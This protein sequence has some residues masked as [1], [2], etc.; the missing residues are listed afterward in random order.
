MKK[1]I[2][3]IGICWLGLTLT[4]LGAGFN[5]T[6][7]EEAPDAG[8]PDGFGVYG[9]ETSDRGVTENVS[10]SG[11]QAASITADFGMD[12]WGVI[13]LHEKGNWD[14]ANK[15]LSAQISSTVDFTGKKGVAAFKLIDADGSEYRT[16]DGDLFTPSGDWKEFR[17]SVS[18][19][20]QVEEPGKKPGLDLGHIVQ[21]GIIFFDHGEYDQVVTF[22]VDDFQTISQ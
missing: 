13:L 11:K 12:K 3:W 6:F 18:S 14:L 17:Q 10:T 9:D 8:A 2:Q 1:R 4:A 21:Y 19:V 7:D 15:T 20:S 22:F 16:R 5:N